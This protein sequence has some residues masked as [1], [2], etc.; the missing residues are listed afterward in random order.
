MKLFGKRKDKDVSE[1]GETSSNIVVVSAK[2]PKFS[3]LKSAFHLSKKKSLVAGMLLLVVAVGV[4]YQAFKVQTYHVGNY[5]I[6]KTDIRLATEAQRKAA[7]AAGGNTKDTTALEKAAQNQLVLLAGLKT[8]ADK[9]GISYSEA[10]VD[11]FLKDAFDSRG[12]KTGY[13]QYMQ[14]SYGWNKTDVYRHRTT[15]YLQQKLGTDLIATRTYSTTFVRWDN[16]KSYYPE[17]FNELYAEKENLLKTV[18]LPL[19]QQKA[20][21]QVLAQKAQL[22]DG[23]SSKQQQQ[24]FND[25]QGVPIIYTQQH[26]GVGHLIDDFEKY[27]EGEDMSTKLMS[28]NIVGDYTGPFKS[29][30][31]TL[32]IA[33]LDKAEGGKFGS[34]R[35]FTEYYKKQSGVTFA[36]S[37]LK[38]V[39]STVLR[40]IKK[41]GNIFTPQIASAAG[42]DCLS[43]HKLTYVIDWV[44]ANTGTK[45]GGGIANSSVTGQTER[46]TSNCTQDGYTSRGYKVGTQCPG[47]DG[48]SSY[49]VCKTFV[50]NNAGSMTVIIDCN[51]PSWDGVSN[52]DNGVVI[53]IGGYTWES[54]TYGS[55]ATN[56][57]PFFSGVNGSGVFTTTVKYNKNPPPAD[58]TLST[59]GP[60]LDNASPR[61]GTTIT[62]THWVHNNCSS[63][64][65]ATSIGWNH[66]TSNEPPAANVGVSNGTIASIPVC[67]DSATSAHSYTIPAS[68]AVGS[69]VCEATKYTLSTGPGSVSAFGPGS[70]PAA[71]YTCAIVAAA[72]GSPSC[73]IS[74][75]PSTINAGNVTTVS[76]SSSGGATAVSVKDSF[77]SSVTSGAS[78]GSINRTPPSTVD[79]TGTTSGG[80][81]TGTC[82]TTVTVNS[83]TPPPPP[84]PPANPPSI[85]AS[86][87]CV[88]G[89]TFTVQDPDYPAAEI[90]GTISSSAGSIG[91]TTSGH[92]YTV[93]VPAS[94]LDGQRHN[95]SISAN[96]VNATGL[97]DG[98]NASSGTIMLACGH[99]TTQPTTTNNLTPD[100]QA[101]TGYAVTGTLAINFDPGVTNA[102]GLYG[103]GISMTCNQSATKTAVGGAVTDLGNT[104]CDGTYTANGPNN[105]PAGPSGTVSSPTAGDQYCSAISVSLASGILEEGGTIY[106]VTGPQSA[107]SPCDYVTNKPYFKVV[108]SS[109]AAGG[110]IGQCTATAGT[111]TLS[112]WFNNS[113]VSYSYGASAQLGAYALAHIAGFA[114]NQTNGLR[115]PTGLTFANTPAGGGN[116]TTDSSS[117][118]LGGSI[119]G[120]NCITAAAVVPNG[121]PAS[122][123]GSVN[124]TPLLASGSPGSIV[125]NY[126]SNISIKNPGSKLVSAGMNVGIYV[127][128]DIYIKDDIVYNLS[129][130]T[131]DT[132]PSM[133]IAATGNIYIDASVSQLDGT[134]E[135]GGSI[136][137]CATGG[138]FAPVSL[139]NLYSSC[140]NKLTITGSFVAQKVNFLRTYGSLRDES[141]VSGVPPPSYTCTSASGPTVNQQNCGSEVF[142]FSPEQYLEHPAA[143]LPGGGALQYDAITSLPPVL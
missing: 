37:T 50:D 125:R 49:T 119:N 56:A 92:N 128:G 93:A 88:S 80:T 30:D 21:P 57:Y 19:Y 77:G 78:S 10:T 66:T 44:D 20:S 52:T 46:V 1:K 121:N 91:Y 122:G 94:F 54:T 100:D 51:G 130:W 35:A 7:K 5:S 62:F 95:F 8:E 104:A 43:S 131:I 84:P 60:T 47:G 127:T 72:P 68:M 143:K 135:A 25:T 86:G 82:T 40:N 24:I 112:S 76:Y 101:P 118:Y 73:S 29:N 27:P 124:L 6:N 67:S 17:K 120:N 33:R 117:P 26:F 70:G 36:P 32:I 87:N 111:G 96:G 65:P 61:P 90:S 74:A 79:Y 126:N 53:G 11:G 23:L 83:S 75:S 113:S 4:S 123:G 108:N 39:S 115:D 142:T 106:N 89:F 97:N 15:E 16:I 140:S 34:W 138:A 14:A 107:I 134:Y 129:G 64:N 28:L 137:T 13:F 141:P 38:Q 114:S 102:Q 139:G 116:I 2:P 99:F 48:G 41:F 42:V 9:R 63:P 81:G 55:G 18:Y 58:W 85:S 3:G 109:V 136:F 69:K 22:M 110:Q 103:Q 133:V 105:L 132:V 12:G 59:T 71:P 31:G 98:T 45:I